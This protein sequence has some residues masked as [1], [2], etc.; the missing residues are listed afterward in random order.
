MV[1]K[2]LLGYRNICATV[3]LSPTLQLQIAALALSGHLSSLSLALRV[4]LS[5][6]EFSSQLAAN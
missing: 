2:A 3:S 4:L 6:A 1:L 5:L